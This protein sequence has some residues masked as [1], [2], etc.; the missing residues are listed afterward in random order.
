MKAVSKY[1]NVHRIVYD[2]K[3]L[4]NSPQIKPNQIKSKCD[5]DKTPPTERHASSYLSYL[6]TPT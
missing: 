6:K 4:D 5:S 3:D 2:L 1:R